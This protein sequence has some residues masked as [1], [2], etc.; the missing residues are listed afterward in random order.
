MALDR[1]GHRLAGPA[2]SMGAKLFDAEGN[3]AVV[4]DGFR[5]MVEMFVGWHEDGTMAQ[6]VWAGQGGAA[7]QDAAQEFIN[8]NLVYYYS[9]S[10]QVG[11][12]EEAIGD[13]FDWQA[14]GV[15]CGPGGCTGMPGGAGLVGFKD[16]AEP[17][18][19]AEVIDF[20]ASEEVHAELIART[21]NV[22][23]HKG[24]AEKGLDYP[25]TAPQAAAALQTFARQVP[26]I[27][28]IAYKL[29]GYALNRAIFNTIAQRV[30]Q[31]IVGEMTVD[32]ALT[33]IGAD[34]DEAVAQSRQ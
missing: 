27:S 13:A 9:G 7:Y 28:P 30:T 6:D 22:P 32:E 15:P 8:A 16:T 21:K 33:R 31:A 2:I 20:F 4:D 11:R 29:Q 19:V 23:A 14:V 25:D 24:L 1:S 3:P 26:K 17:E 18:A 10:W 5:Q 34:V 12:F